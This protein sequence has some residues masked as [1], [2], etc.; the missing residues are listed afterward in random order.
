AAQWSRNGGTL[1]TLDLRQSGSYPFAANVVSPAVQ[2]E[3]RSEA[4]YAKRDAVLGMGDPR[5]PAL[6]DEVAAAMTQW[7]RE[8]GAPYGAHIC[9]R[10]RGLGAG[11]HDCFCGPGGDGAPIAEVKGSGLSQR[12]PCPTSRP[13]GGVRATCDARGQTAWDPTRPAFVLETP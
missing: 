11:K 3:R 4:C 13:T 10:L 2:K 12:V 5:D 1:G 9:Q 7:A 6:A 8:Q